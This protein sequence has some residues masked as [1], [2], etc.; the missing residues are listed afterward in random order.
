MSGCWETVCCL[1]ALHGRVSTCSFGCSNK[2]SL[3]TI[4]FQCF[5]AHEVISFAE[6]CQSA[7]PPEGSTVTSFH[8]WFPSLP[9]VWRDF[10]RFLETFDGIMGSSSWLWKEIVRKLLYYLPTQFF[11]NFIIHEDLPLSRVLHHIQLDISMFWT[12]GP[13]QQVT[14]MNVVCVLPDCLLLPTVMRGLRSMPL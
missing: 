14:W 5:Q 13:K 12:V 4:V 7:V 1:C 11:L 6:L 10:S 9:L 2:L 8:C 3:L